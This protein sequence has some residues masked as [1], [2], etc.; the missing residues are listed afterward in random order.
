M[1]FVG[2]ERQISVV[3]SIHQVI[4][5]A[6]NLW[7]MSDQGSSSNINTASSNTPIWNNQNPQSSLVLVGNR[8]SISLSSVYP[9][10]QETP[11]SMKCPIKV[12]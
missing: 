8:A 5:A 12:H 11:V 7:K 9:E 1:T 3:V 2:L 10:T 4:I 6:L